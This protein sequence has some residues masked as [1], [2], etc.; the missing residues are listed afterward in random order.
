[1][2]LIAKAYELVYDIRSGCHGVGNLGV[3]FQNGEAHGANDLACY[4]FIPNEIHPTKEKPGKYFVQAVQPSSR[5]C[6]YLGEYR[7]FCDWIGNKSH[8]SHIYVTKNRNFMALVGTIFDMEKCNTH[9]GINVANFHRDFYEHP[10]RILGWDLFTRAGCEPHLALVLAHFFYPIKG[11]MKGNNFATVDIFAMNQAF[12][13]HS[14]WNRYSLSKEVIRNVVE[15]NINDTSKLFAEG[16]RTSGRSNIWG[17][18]SIGKADEQKPLMAND[19]PGYV[20]EEIKTAWGE[21]RIN[22]HFRTSDLENTVKIWQEFFL[23]GKT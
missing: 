18:A 19:I 13:G 12:G 5:T 4:N 22:R 1:M 14:T 3:V 10:Y 11:E 6:K 21:S 20:E 7:R 17:Q 2:D 23:G 16:I 8:W 15:N 9:L